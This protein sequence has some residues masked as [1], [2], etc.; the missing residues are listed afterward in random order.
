MRAQPNNG[1]QGFKGGLN[2]A[3]L[4]YA[5]AVAADPVSVSTLHT[6][7]NEKN[8]RPLTNLGAPGV[9]GQGK[10]DVNQNFL[11]EFDYPTHSFL[12]N[13]VSFK[14]PSTPVLLQITSGA[15]TPE[16]LLPKGSIYSL[17]A[18]KVIEMSFP[19][20]SAG[21]PV[22]VLCESDLHLLC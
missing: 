15:H 20:G 12:V 18:N 4:R 10:A 8:L 3:I 16:E 22:R 19:G 17:P 14:S 5:G 1:N 7:L 2:S 9:H 6:P 13:K 21:S 11:I